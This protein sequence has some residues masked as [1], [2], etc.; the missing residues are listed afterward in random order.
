MDYKEAV[1]FFV[2]CAIHAPSQACIYTECT[3]GH[4]AHSLLPTGSPF[5]Q[6]ALALDSKVYNRYLTRYKYE[7]LTHE[8]EQDIETK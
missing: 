8:F 1:L 6:P 3:G 7:C 4:M 2:T 5:T